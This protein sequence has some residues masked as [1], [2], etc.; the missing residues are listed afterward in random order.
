MMKGDKN[1]KRKI[2]TGLGIVSGFLLSGGIALAETPTAT[3]TL[4]TIMGT[5]IN[6]TVELATTVF[7]TYWPYV[8][9][10][11]IIAALVVAFKKFAHIG[12]K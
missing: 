2:L 5:V 1:M 3:S 10:I 6:T 12:A 7:S 8:L 11:G 9:V 4:N